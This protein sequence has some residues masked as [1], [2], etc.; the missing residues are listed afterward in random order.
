[1]IADRPAST[2]GELSI[3]SVDNGSMLL[4]GRLVRMTFPPDGRTTK[5]SDFRLHVPEQNTLEAEM[6]TSGYELGMRENTFDR[7]VSR[8]V[9]ARPILYYSQ[10]V[11]Q[12]CPTRS[13]ASQ[14]DSIQVLLLFPYIFNRD[15]CHLVRLMQTTDP[16]N[17]D[18]G[19]TPANRRGWPI[20]K[21]NQSPTLKTTS[22]VW[23][24]VRCPAWETCVHDGKIVQ[25]SEVGMFS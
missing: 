5:N 10:N 25:V 15:G 23:F 2:S 18:L 9:T 20:A 16:S 7:S 6:F 11:H 14:E 4:N 22:E 1:L 21:P 8:L 13:D 17:S 12:L 3:L 24:C 19:F